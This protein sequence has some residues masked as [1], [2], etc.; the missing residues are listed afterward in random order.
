M[1]ALIAVIYSS[2][3]T[4]G[5]DWRPSHVDKRNL[6]FTTRYWVCHTR[7]CLWII[8]DLYLILVS[9]GGEHDKPSKKGLLGQRKDKKDSKKDRGY[10]A[11]EGESSPEEDTDTKLIFSYVKATYYRLIIIIFHYLWYTDFKLHF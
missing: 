11:L 9:D 2:E 3:G 6:I 10:A 4:H 1:C 8:F 5:F 7:A